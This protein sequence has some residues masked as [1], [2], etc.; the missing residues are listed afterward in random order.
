VELR[1][2]QF[3]SDADRLIGNILQV[4][5]APKP[6]GRWWWMALVGSSALVMLVLI[7]S[8]YLNNWWTRFG[9]AVN[10]ETCDRTLGPIE[11]G[12]IFSGIFS[13]V[14][15]DSAQGGAEAQVKLVRSQNTVKGSYLRAGICG[16]IVGEIV[17][18]RM[19]F[20]WSWAGNAGRGTG[21]FSEDSLSGT[22]GLK[23]Q[24]EGG[25]TFIL[26]RRKSS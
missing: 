13:G 22:S 25:G 5:K 26:F 8:P 18:D 1:N 11:P 14:V 7:A 6:R 20:R 21:T 15:V 16:T 9:S 3:S 23:E 10:I 2:T 24:T 17:N 12:D 4:L 19:I